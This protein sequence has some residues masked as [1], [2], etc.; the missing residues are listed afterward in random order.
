MPLIPYAR[1]EV[2]RA[3][4][5]AVLRVLRSSRLTQGSEVEAFEEKLCEATGARFAVCVSSGTLALE[6]AYQA[7]GV[8]PELGVACPTVT[9]MATANAARRLGAVVRFHERLYLLAADG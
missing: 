3:D 4:E 6:L 8:G 5:A 9:F 7:L 2:T 1:H